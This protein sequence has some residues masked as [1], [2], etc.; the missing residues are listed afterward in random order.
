ML[1][2]FVDT[3]HD[4][5]TTTWTQQNISES[6][7]NSDVDSSY[8]IRT[9]FMNFSSFVSVRLTVPEGMKCKVFYYSASSASSFL[10][11]H[12]WFENEAVVYSSIGSRVRF[13]LTKKD[14]TTIAPADASGVRMVVHRNTIPTEGV[15]INGISLDADIGAFRTL[16]VSGRESIEAE[17]LEVETETLDGNIYHGKRYEPRTLTIQFQLLCKTQAEMND[18]VDRLNYLLGDEELKVSFADLPDRYYIGNKTRLNP[19]ETGRLNVVGSFEIYCS[20][21][22]AYSEEEF[23]VTLGTDAEDIGQ[24]IQ[25]NGTAPAYPTF[26]VDVASDTGAL[27][28]A[29]ARVS[30]YDSATVTLG[31]AT[32]DVEV[33]PNYEFDLDGGNFVRVTHNGSTSTDSNILFTK[34]AA[35]LKTSATVTQNGTISF[36]NNAKGSKFGMYLSAV[37]SGDQWHGGGYRITFPASY[38]ES[39][40]PFEMTFDPKFIVSAISQTG[41]MQINLETATGAGTVAAITFWKTNRSDKVVHVSMIVG[42]TTQ[43]AHNEQVVALDNNYF[44][45]LGSDEAGIARF[46]DKIYFYL[47]GLRWA[48]YAPLPAVQYVRYVSF[49]IGTYGANTAA[50]M[51]IAHWHMRQYTNDVDGLTEAPFR[52]NS[53]D[54]VMC[55]MGSASVLVNGNTETR[56]NNLDNDFEDFV[57]K[58]GSNTVWYDYSSYASRPTV[59]MHYREVY[60]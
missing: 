11:S 18:A 32:N 23:V 47:G 10:E 4:A 28:F 25:Y 29:V 3:R 13:L 44:T 19:F 60:L 14:G 43:S 5:Y 58:N 22:F 8:F 7:A 30:D 59:K 34:N 38:Y 54:K 33:S 46:G 17:I 21:P 15:F 55:Y 45:G 16:S 26:E 12:G 6:G 41:M 1:Y 31:N 42:D 50:D 39:G 35:V 37:G 20:D 24:S 53:G 9:N 2:G 56:A 40:M 36:K 52:F 49:F 51:A 57:L 48:F 27:Q